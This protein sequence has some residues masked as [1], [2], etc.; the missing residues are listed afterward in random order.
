MEFPDPLI[1]TLLHEFEE[2]VR[3]ISVCRSES[4]FE[5]A[6]ALCELSR[7]ICF[8]IGPRRYADKSQVDRVAA[9]LEE[10]AISLPIL[11]DNT[12]VESYRR[13]ILSRADRLRSDVDATGVP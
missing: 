10:A 11:K 1:E 7:D 8:Q 9:V 2:I 3:A 4:Q 5:L 12:T 6:A 13:N